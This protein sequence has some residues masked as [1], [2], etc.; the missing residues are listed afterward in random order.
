MAA[1]FAMQLKEVTLAVL[2]R[3][4]REGKQ[5]SE[6][7]PKVN[8]RQTCLKSMVLSVRVGVSAVLCFLD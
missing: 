2:D 4:T 1:D 5:L 3:T 8:D 6:S 7:V